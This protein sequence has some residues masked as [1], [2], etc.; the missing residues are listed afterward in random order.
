VLLP[1]QTRWLPF[2]AEEGSG[3]LYLVIQMSE[4]ICGKLP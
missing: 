3:L 1:A 4:S 2:A